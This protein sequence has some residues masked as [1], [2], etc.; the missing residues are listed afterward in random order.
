MATHYEIHPAADI[1]PMMTEEEYTGLRDDIREHGQRDNG[2]ICDGK[3]LDG[4]NRYRACQEMGIEFQYYE[5]EPDD[6]PI[7][8]VLSVNLHRRNLTRKQRNE[9]I[10]KL[11]AM[12]RTCQQ[13]ADATGVNKSTVSRVVA[14]A[15]TE[16]P[17][18][19]KGK[20]GKKYPARKRRRRPASE[21][22]SA[23]Q[24]RIRVDGERCQK[25]IDGERRGDDD[26]GELL[27][28]MD[29]D[30]TIHFADDQPQLPPTSMAVAF[31]NE[32]T[33]CVHRY[34]GM[35]L[36]ETAIV[37]V[38]KC[39]K[40]DLHGDGDVDNIQP[41][42]NLLGP[43]LDVDGC[44]TDIGDVV[45]KW[46]RTCQLSDL[47]RLAHILE[48]LAVQVVAQHDDL[49]DGVEHLENAVEAA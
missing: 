11:R 48:Q 18:T 30:G 3:I 26:D 15:T 29:D 40:E 36:P 14:N 12:G 2:I 7:S 1:F 21:P 24:V 47:L 41:K 28:T 44:I 19:V 10:E 34:R 35:G 8:Y 16:T 6:D 23:C 45:K 27:A 42:D 46:S 9:V 5:L 25:C 4:R 20:D 39:I 31:E 22:C 37:N 17:S 43:G 33:D 32:L 13:I 49:Q 38:V